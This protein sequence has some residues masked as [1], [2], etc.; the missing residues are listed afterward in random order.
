MFGYALGDRAD[1]LRA[2][3]G[4][5]G[6]AHPP[7]ARRRPGQLRRALL[8]AAGRGAGAAPA[9]PR[10]P[11]NPDR[12]R[13]APGAPCRW[14]PATP[15]SGT[16]KAKPA[17]GARARGAARP[18]A[19]GGGPTPRGRAPHHERAGVL[20]AH[21]GRAGTPDAGRPPLAGVGALP[22]DAARGDPARGV[23][24]PSSGRP[25]RSSRSCAPTPRR[26]SPRCRCGGSTRTTSTGSNSWRPRSS[27]SWDHHR[28][29]GAGASPGS[30]SR[31]AQ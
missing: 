15:T 4:G 5:A 8:P 24:P 30:R 22:L 2:P 23:R 9:A 29:T 3:G 27:R 10:R 21:P 25:R 20:R 7:A 11:A 14:W 6:G 26:G 17:G 13:T 18:A 12:R 28:L 1:P 16:C 31:T 19:G